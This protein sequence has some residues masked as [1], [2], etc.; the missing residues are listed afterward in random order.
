MYAL[1]TRLYEATNIARNAGDIALDYFKQWSKLDITQKTNPQDLVSEADHKVESYIRKA[2]AAKYPTDNFLGE[3]YGLTDNQNKEALTW[4]IDPIDGTYAFL[5]GIPLWCISIA[6]LYRGK[7]VLG[8]IADPN[9]GEIFTAIKGQ[10][11]FCNDSPIHTIKNANLQSGSI[12]FGID[13]DERA[14]IAKKFINSSIEKN[15]HIARTYTCAL[16]MAW[17]AGGRMLGAF[18]PYVHAWDFCAGLVLIEEAGGKHNNPLK[19]HDWAN[20]KGTALL[21]SASE[22]Y[23]ELAQLCHIEYLSNLY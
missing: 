6:A 23:D 21:A 11:A 17:T 14:E 5:H 1:Q 18:Y 13:K 12:A 8:I 20:N 19:N 10:G 9:H 7:P 15:I 16:N 3:E 4:V 2:L 22:T